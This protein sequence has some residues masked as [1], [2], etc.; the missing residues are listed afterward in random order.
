MKP[1]HSYATLMNDMFDSQNDP[2][3]EWNKHDQLCKYCIEGFC[4]EELGSWFVKRLVKGMAVNAPENVPYID[5]RI[6][7]EGYQ[8]TE[9][10]W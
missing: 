3:S 7:L 2:D 5:Q 10:C 6:A 1:T 4:E 9:D 8:F